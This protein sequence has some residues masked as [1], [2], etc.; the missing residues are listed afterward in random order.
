[1]N[2][3]NG[4]IEKTIEASTPDYLKE[5]KANQN[6]PN[7][8]VIL[9]DDLGFSQLGCYGSDIHTPHIDQLATNGLRYNNFH[10]TAICSPTRAAL[11]TGRNPHS[12]G[13]SFV[14]HHDS[15]YPNGRSKISQDTAL[16]SEVLVEKGYNTFAVGKWH[17]AP[18]LELSAA[19]PYNNWPLG[20]GFENFYGFL[21]GAT[22]QWFP[23]L[24]RDNSRISQPKTPEEGYH[25]TEDLTDALI[26]YIKNQ[27]TA[28][29]QKPFFGYL[30][31]GAT[32]APHHAPQAYINK[33]KGQYDEGW[34]VVR[35]KW[36]LK[37]KELGIIPEST[38]LPDR[39]PDVPAWELLS[40]QQKN[41]YARLQET[42]AGFLE[43]TDYHIGR[44]I[45]FLKEI[46]ELDNTLVVL[47]SDNGACSMG[48]DDGTVNTWS[49]TLSASKESFEEKYKRLNEIGS[50]LAN[51][52]YPKGWAQVGN[53][54]LKWYKSF[55]HAGGIKDPL[56]IHYP[57]KI[58]DK[59][60]IRSQY[61]HVVDIVPT[62]LEVLELEHP[63]VIKGVEQKNIDG[64]SLGYTFASNDIATQKKIQHYEMIGN[65]AIWKEGWKAVAKHT[66]DTSFE[67]DEWELYHVENDFSENHNLAEEYPEKLNELIQTWWQE[68]EKYDVF[69][70][71][72]RSIQAKIK[73]VQKDRK[74]EQGPIQRVYLP[75]KTRHHSSVA[76]D[77]RNKSFEVRLHLKVEGNKNGVLLSSGDVSSGYVLFFQDNKLTFD[78]NVNG[79]EHY[80]VRSIPI[81]KTG[82]LKIR[83]QLIKTTENEGTIR[84]L[85]EN[86]VIGEGAIKQTDKLGFSRGSLQFYQNQ[87]SPISKKYKSPFPFE[88]KI[89]QVIYT[90]GGYTED[91][92]ASLQEELATE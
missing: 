67:F 60:G 16:I 65:R 41:L 91:L 13:V 75:T 9:L 73:S 27:K 20:R 14:A 80:I 6:H 7:V 83:I 71:D 86:K 28:N 35:E 59:G 81:T 62:I 50:P 2:T 64:T 36:F 17:L 19:G 46:N 52:H 25:L 5:V 84:L 79:T 21:E 34:D 61:H 55:V 4:K 30:A 45:N 66:P 23:D 15:G 11:L 47:L 31:Y 51:N 74:K 85:Q 1:M 69:P 58:T 70:L 63:H 22:N 3:F 88:G 32:H 12:T 44:I 40:D 24:V 78:Y 56:I 53:T 29:N 10:T 26:D 92:E 8:L 87:Q 89:N 43:H 54:P 37:Q 76:P 18:G 38:T 39:S 33:Y 72:G 48:G 57:N 82:E 77:I 68:A 49:E 42:F 90:L